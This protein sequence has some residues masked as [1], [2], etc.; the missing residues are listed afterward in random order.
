LWTGGDVDDGGRTEGVDLAAVVPLAAGGAA[1]WA[2]AS[3]GAS[4]G[5]GFLDEWFFDP[6]A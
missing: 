6:V 4:R 5:G 3:N 2:S 1:R